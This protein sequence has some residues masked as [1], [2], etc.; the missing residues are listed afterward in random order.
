MQISV[1]AHVLAVVTMLL[2]LPHPAV[3]TG[4]WSLSWQA[5]RTCCQLVFCPTAAAAAAAA[6]AASACGVACITWLPE[7]PAGHRTLSLP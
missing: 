2:A 5:R 6:A 1:Y 4:A 3:L 7:L